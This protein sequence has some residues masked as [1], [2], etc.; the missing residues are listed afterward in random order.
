MAIAT[1]IL[2]RYAPT[3]T[4]LLPLGLTGQAEGQ[5]VAEEGRAAGI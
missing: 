5:F 2:D 3:Q 1:C 4:Y